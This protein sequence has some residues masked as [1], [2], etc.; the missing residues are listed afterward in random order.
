M[1]GEAFYKT[2][3]WQKLRAEVLGRD[4][5]KCAVKGCF[6]KATVVDHIISRPR[7]LIWKCKED[8][9]EN[10]RSLCTDHDNQVKEG[11]NGERRGNGEFFVRGCDR[12]GF[13]VDPNHPWAKE[14]KESGYEKERL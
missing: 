9:K 3:F 10:L 8:A 1:A 5:Y 7:G 11:K 4:N 2:S 6:E 12:N 14:L 13:P